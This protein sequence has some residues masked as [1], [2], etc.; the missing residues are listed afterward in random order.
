MAVADNSSRGSPPDPHVIESLAEVNSAPIEHVRALYEEVHAKLE[1][2]ARI[3]TYVSV[4][5]TRLV[6]NA[7]IAEKYSNA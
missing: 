4:I 3:K 2:D 1:N 6:R 5:A 7:L